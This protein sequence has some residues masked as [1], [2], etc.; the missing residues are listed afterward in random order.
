MVSTDQLAGVSQTA[1]SA[2]S[3]LLKLP[4]ELR[5]K[6]YEFVLSERIYIT[7]ETE[8]PYKPGLLQVN[9]QIRSETRTMFYHLA[10]F[11]GRRLPY[12]YQEV[13]QWGSNTSDHE[14]RNIQ[15]LSIDMNFGYYRDD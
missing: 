12:T 15:D 14:L 2:A 10:T 3:H 5:N 13:R 6:I 9:R 4:P 1:P 11:A 7:D 8:R